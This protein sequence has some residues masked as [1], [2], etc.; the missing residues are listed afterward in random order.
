MRTSSASLSRTRRG[1]TLVEILTALAITTV[2][3]VALVSMFNTSTK[4]LIAANR[5][6]DVWEEA[7]A[8]FGLL[9][10]DISD[11][12]VGGSTNRVNLYANGTIVSSLPNQF[13]G[14]IYNRLQ[15]I[16]I[17]SNEGGVWGATVYRVMRETANAGVGTLHRFQTNYPSFRVGVGSGVLPIDE[18]VNDLNHPLRTAYD[19]SLDPSQ[20]Q[21]KKLVEG[22]VHL[23][24]VAFAEDGRAYTNRADL[25]E[26]PVPDDHFISHD[27]LVFTGGSLPAHVDL[28]LLVLEPDRIEEFRAQAT[29]DAKRLYLERHVGSIQVFR[30]RIPI[31]RDAYA[32]K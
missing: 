4:A 19:P 18:P 7:R 13:V 1:F 25:P 3:V 20:N 31:R 14:A 24:I 23:R 2:I 11:V 12:A 5:Q 10:S 30:T 9:R 21:F 16:Y 27:R 17:L 15:E 32:L 26:P 22:V 28:E 6:T 29:E 8:A